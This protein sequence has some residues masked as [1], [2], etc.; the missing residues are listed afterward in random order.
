[1]PQVKAIVSMSWVRLL[2]NILAPP[3]PPPPVRIDPGVGSS[4]IFTIPSTTYTLRRDYIHYSRAACDYSHFY[5]H[6]PFAFSGH[7]VWSLLVLTFREAIKITFNFA[8][9]WDH[10]DH[11]QSWHSVR[12]FW[13]LSILIQ[14]KSNENKKFERRLKAGWCTCH[15][16]NFPTTC[17]FIHKRA[18][19]FSNPTDPSRCSATVAFSLQ[20]AALL[21][22]YF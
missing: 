4:A 18:N 11:F 15:V 17:G 13:S 19:R 10:Y 22:N 20:V 5:D 21:T 8:I 7:C 6:S 12:P 3:P 1:M 2:V 14:W 9:P 16:T